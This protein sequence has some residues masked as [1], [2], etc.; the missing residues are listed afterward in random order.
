LITQNFKVILKYNYSTSYALSVAHLGDRI[1]GGQRF[2][3]KWPVAEQPLSLEE[4]EELQTLLNARG[5]DVGTVDGVLGLKTR[6]AARIF[7]KEIGWPQDG[8]VNKALLNELR[9]RKSA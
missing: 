9:R 5:L 4:R 6:K 8:F 2:A 1:L 3:G 7:Q